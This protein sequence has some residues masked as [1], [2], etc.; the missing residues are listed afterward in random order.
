LL[1]F[2]KRD[3][4][5]KK[6]EACQFVKTDVLRLGDK[7]QVNHFHKAELLKRRGLT[8]DL[9]NKWSDSKKALVEIQSHEEEYQKVAGALTE[10]MSDAHI[11]KLWRIQNKSLW[12][13]YSFHKDRLS[14]N[15]IPHNEMNVWHGTSSMDPALIYN[16][17]QDGFMMQYSRSGLWG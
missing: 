3:D 13:Y 12:T 14:M 7:D 16:D 17:K 1:T 4:K 10:S 6:I 5:A 8:Q 2:R 9:P 15:G 11:S